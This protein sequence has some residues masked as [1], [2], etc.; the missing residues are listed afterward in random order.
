MTKQTTA[1]FCTELGNE[2]TRLTDMAV[3]TEAAAL[4]GIE[5]LEREP[6]SDYFFVRVADDWPE[7]YLRVVDDMWIETDEDW[8]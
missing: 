6:E 3:V 4:V 1:L 5:I 7:H 8:S 2:S